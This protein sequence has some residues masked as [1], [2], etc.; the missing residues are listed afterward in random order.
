M[1]LSLL[2]LILFDTFTRLLLGTQ[3]KIPYQAT[4]CVITGLNFS[5]WYRCRPNGLLFLSLD[6]SKRSSCRFFVPSLPLRELLFL[7]QRRNSAHIRVKRLILE[8][9]MIWGETNHAV[10]G[11]FWNSRKRS[12]SHGVRRRRRQI[13]RAKKCTVDDK[14]IGLNRQTY[15]LL[16]VAQKTRKKN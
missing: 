15:R 8:R 5:R 4:L 12:Q 7:V 13:E 6:T 14:K 3:Q 2:I 9:W 1:Y 10:L 16:L 11:I